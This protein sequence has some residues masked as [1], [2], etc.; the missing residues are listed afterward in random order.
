MSFNLFFL[1]VLYK[2]RTYTHLKK[3]GNLP[4]GIGGIGGPIIRPFIIGPEFWGLMGGPPPIM[5]GGP[6]LPIMP[7]GPPPPIMLGGPPPPIMLG[8]PPPI[9]G[10]GGLGIEG[11]AGG[12]IVEDA[13]DF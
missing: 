6:P 11:I 10:I 9:M 3:S 8:G 1:E 2:K 13:N 5:L 12:E 4:G 7:G